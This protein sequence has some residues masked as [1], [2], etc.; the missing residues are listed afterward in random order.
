MFYRKSTLHRVVPH[1]DSLIQRL[2]LQKPMRYGPP[3]FARI[4]WLE[5][6][7]NYKI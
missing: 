5:F 4:I 6:G 3:K 1:P 7:L 2:W